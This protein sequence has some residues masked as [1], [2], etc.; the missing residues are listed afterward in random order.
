MQCRAFHNCRNRVWHRSK[1]F[2]GDEANGKYV[3]KKTAANCQIDY[4]SFEARPLPSDVMAKSHQAFS[5][6][7]KHSKKLIAALP[8][9]WPGL[10]RCNF[11]GGKLRL[12]LIYGDAND[13]LAN[14]EFLLMRGFWTGFHQPKT[15]SCGTVICC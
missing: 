14:I 1:F 8:P 7:K 2:G 11:L 6:L 4:I 10:H 12:H 9:R 13:T 3:G 15:L 5:S